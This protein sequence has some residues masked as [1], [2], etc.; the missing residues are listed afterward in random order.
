[1]CSTLCC[2]FHIAHCFSQ[3]AFINFCK[4]LMSVA[5]PWL[6]LINECSSNMNV[7]DIF[8]YLMSKMKMK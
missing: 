6:Q 8:G 2:K 1:M 5:I 4:I 3:N 7:V